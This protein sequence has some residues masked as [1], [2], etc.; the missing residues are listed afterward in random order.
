M[1]GSLHEQPAGQDELLEE[2]GQDEGDVPG[3]GPVAD[4]R[5]QAAAVAAM[6]SAPVTVAVLRVELMAMYSVR[7]RTVSCHRE[8]TPSVVSEDLQLGRPTG[9]G[10]LPQVA[11]RRCGGT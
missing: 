3:D 7:D 9:C 6:N 10:V 2:N 5:Q 8:S 4:K 1:G 11:A